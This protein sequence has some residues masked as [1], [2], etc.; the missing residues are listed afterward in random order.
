[1]DRSSPPRTWYDLWDSD[2]V[3]RS[4]PQ[5]T[6][7]TPT[8]ADTRSISSLKLASWCL[9]SVVLPMY[10]AHSIHCSR[11][12]QQSQVMWD[13]P[14]S[15]H[16]P[17]Y[18]VSLWPHHLSCPVT[19]SYQCSMCGETAVA[20]WL[21]LMRDMTAGCTVECSTIWT[22]LHNSQ[23]NCEA[24]HVW[25]W[26]VLRHFGTDPELSRH[27]GTINMVPMCLGTKVSLSR[28]VLLP[29]SHAVTYSRYC[30]C[31]A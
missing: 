28:S 16:F 14:T 20:F 5:C 19:R 4:Q 17:Y 21:I 15:S 22:D 24:V 10:T 31:T 30:R 2:L 11:H 23:R 25:S 18:A 12:Q 3:H 27:F 26:T 8:F 7:D 13:Q 6:V 29:C 1:M 9:S